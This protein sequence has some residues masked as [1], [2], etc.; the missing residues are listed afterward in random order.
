[1]EADASMQLNH[2]LCP[3]DFSDL[4]ARALRY[5]G[6][7][8][9]RLNAHLTV[10]YA[11]S[12]SAPPYFTQSRLEDLERQFRESFQEAETAL[13]RFVQEQMRGVAHGEVDVR[14][15]EGLPVDAIRK[16]AKESHADLI[17]MGTH[18]CS[19]LN[20]LMLGSVTERLLRESEVPV[21]TVR[22]DMAAAA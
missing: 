20:R 5:A 18:G 4:S 11:N 9:G 19:G 22:G 7:L 15:I 6:M 13:R 21:L 16:T 14:V 3:V 10:V 12:F 17:V 1:V 2:I 8:A